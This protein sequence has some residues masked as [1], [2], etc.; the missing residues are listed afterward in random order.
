MKK[1]VIF[2]TAHGSNVPG[3]QSPD[4]KFR[5]YAWSRKIINL[6]KPKL[7]AKGFTVYVDILQDLVPTPQKVE[8]ESR[9]AIVNKIC[10]N[11]GASN[12]LYLPIHVNA[13]GSDGKWEK[14][15]GWC[16]FTTRGKTKS[17]IAAECLYEEAEIELKDYEMIMANGKKKGIYTKQQRP[18]RTDKTDGDKDLESN[19]YVILHS[20]CPAV[21]VENLFQDNKVDVEYLTSEKGINS[22]VNILVNGAVKYF[23]RL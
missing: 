10:A 11:H 1:V 21:L 15:G 4:G 8:L 5:E 14:A 20:I 18:Y 13:A 22:I 9:V 6:A 23:D 12:C 17:D 19:F 16:A 7:E 2:G 3:K